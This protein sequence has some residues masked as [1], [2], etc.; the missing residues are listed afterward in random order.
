ML[1]MPGPRADVDVCTLSRDQGAWGPCSQQDPPP[2]VISRWAHTVC[3][4]CLMQCALLLPLLLLIRFRTIPPAAALSLDMQ[5]KT[6]AM[7]EKGAK[8]GHRVIVT[9]LLC[10]Q[11]QRAHRRLAALF[12]VQGGGAALSGLPAAGGPRDAH[13]PRRR[14]GS[15]AA[16]PLA[17]DPR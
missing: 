5:Y 2:Q 4:R 9:S 6:A 12:C 16:H 10:V 17:P 8:G 7:R 14:A 13:A 11:L 1:S 3:T 15:A